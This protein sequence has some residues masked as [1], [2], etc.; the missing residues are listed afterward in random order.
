MNLHP[1]E[2]WLR[3]RGP[4]GMKWKNSS[5]NVVLVGNTRPVHAWRDTRD[6]HIFPRLADP[7]KALLR[8]QGGPGSH[9]SDHAI[10]FSPLPPPLVASPS[11]LPPFDRAFLPVWPP[12]RCSRPSPALSA[13]GLGSWRGGGLLWRVWWP[14]SVERLVAA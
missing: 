9:V 11:T 6:S 12:T 2:T 1:G 13:H 7:T 8:S 3:E 14:V 5:G 10:G 4:Q